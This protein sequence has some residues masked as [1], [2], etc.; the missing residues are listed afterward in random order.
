MVR[1]DIL[2][3]LKVAVQKGES[4]K[5][6]MI[7]FYNSGY[8]KQEIEEAARALQSQGV[9][10][11]V[12][13]NIPQQKTQQPQQNL[14]PGQPVQKVSSYGP[15]TTPQT[16]PTQ[17]VSSYEPKKKKGKVFVILLVA[18][19]LLLVGLLITVVVFKDQILEFFA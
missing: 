19:L 9:I 8:S 18:I 7:T 16:Q 15:A 5:Q 11:P 4:L 13:Q 10:Q 6:A 2:A 3:G 1:A 12:V 14:A 17:K